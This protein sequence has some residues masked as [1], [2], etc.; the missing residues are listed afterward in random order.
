MGYLFQNL[1]YI[2]SAESHGRGVID[3][4]SGNHTCKLLN[5]LWFDGLF[6]FIQTAV[7]NKMLKCM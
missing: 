4:V 3:G 2:L 7:S 6:N 1:L 5:I